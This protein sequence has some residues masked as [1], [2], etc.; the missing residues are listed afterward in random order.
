[1]QASIHGYK[2]KKSV[3]HIKEGGRLSRSGVG[4]KSATGAIFFFLRLHNGKQR[5]KRLH[6]ATQLV[7]LSLSLF[8]DFML[9]WCYTESNMLSKHIEIQR[10]MASFLR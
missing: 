7:F 3:L 8:S 4:F 5:K 10:F 9:L 6:L 2:C 1:M